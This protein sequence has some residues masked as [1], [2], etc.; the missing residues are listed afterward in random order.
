MCESKVESKS[1]FLEVEA[2]AATFT[3]T[4]RQCMQLWQG[5]EAGVVGME[6]DHP[7]REVCHLASLI[8]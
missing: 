3:F 8:F 7:A 4:A 2:G 5:L 6:D 1:K